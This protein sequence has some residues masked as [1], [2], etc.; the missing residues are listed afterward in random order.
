MLLMLLAAPAQAE[1]TPVTLNQAIQTALEQSL[2]VDEASVETSLGVQS[3]TEGIGGFLPT[4]S[5]ST[6]T[7][8]SSLADL[9]SG[10]WSTRLD[11]S[12]PVVNATTIFGLLNGIKQAGISKAQSRQILGKLI[13]DVENAYYGLARTQALVESA[14]RSYERARE[15]LKLTERRYELKDA[16]NAEK[17]RAEASLLSAE[18]ELISARTSLEQNQRILSDLLGYESTEPFR[19]SELPD[20][21]E[22]YNLSTTI[23]SEA[24]ISENPDYDVL[25]RQARLTDLAYWGAWASI[26]PSLNLTASRSWSQDEVFPSDWDAGTDSYGLSVSIPLADLK[27][28]ALSVNR[29]RLERKNSRISMARQELAFRQQLASLLATQ[30]SSY[31]GW[32]VA[33]KNVELSREVYRLTSRSYELGAASLADLLEVETELVQAE[34]ALVEAKAAYW[35]SRAE[36]NYFLG[37]SLED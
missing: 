5:A 29:A 32:E 21:E 8:D 15:N 2:A 14:E 7:G 4:L 11:L 33:V 1:T 25:K 13:L 19:T 37:T 27:G 24:V 35:T 10:L 18:Q 36:L 12:Q 16:S 9:G 31:K 20:A 26:L 17:L 6:S 30:E 22:P 28:K 3:A 23:I 34:R